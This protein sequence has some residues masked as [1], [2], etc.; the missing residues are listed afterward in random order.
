MS[1]EPKPAAELSALNLCGNGVR[2]QFFWANDRYAHVIDAVGPAG[3]VRILES[4]EGGGE[5]SWPLSPPYQ[6]LI[7]STKENG[8][9]VILMTGSAGNSH[10]SMAAEVATQAF[11]KKTWS[12]YFGSPFQEV[13]PLPFL[14]FETACRLKSEPVWLGT[15]FRAPN[16]DALSEMEPYV[17]TE[18][19]ILGPR[20]N[21][22][23]PDR[24]EI[25]SE[26]RSRLLR[27]EN[28]YVIVQVIPPVHR[29]IQPPRTVRWTYGVFAHYP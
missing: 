8:A 21:F 12:G 26:S 17:F 6:H 27:Q 7:V 29:V 23:D 22:L 5:Q 19:W 9:P 24:P 25:T 3:K 14:L 4:I 10:W 1:A 16:E 28:G 2:A 13:E 20:L 15:T 11:P 18:D